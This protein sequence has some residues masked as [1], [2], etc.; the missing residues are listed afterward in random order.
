MT[1]YTEGMH[2]GEFV[3]S[4]ANG[5]RSR[6]EI[7]VTQA[8]AALSAGQ[9][10]GRITASGKYVPRV[11]TNSNGSEVAAAI[12]YGNLPAATGDVAAV[13]FVRDCEVDGNVLTGYGADATAKA[14][15]KAQLAAVGIIVRV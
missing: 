1:P 4:E 7:V 2:A 9:V 8:G 6:E 10:L 14:V 12:L 15:T 3:L 13:G 5:T 11:T